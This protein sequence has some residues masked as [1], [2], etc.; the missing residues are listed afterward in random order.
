MTQTLS[1]RAE[2]SLA[3]ELDAAAAEAGVP[4]S[5]LLN[6]A[7]REYLYRLRCERDAERYAHQPL[8]PAET[9]AWP[10]E[11]WPDDDTDWTEVFGE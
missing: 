11:A 8:T 10:N 9:T 7:V 3:E 4:R 6:Q 5:D 2:T 1:F